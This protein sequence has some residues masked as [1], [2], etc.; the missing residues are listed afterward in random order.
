[1]LTMAQKIPKLDKIEVTVQPF[2]KYKRSQDL[3]ACFHA[4][5]AAI[6]GIADAI[7]VD[8]SPAH[9]VSLKFMPPVL[10]C[11]KDIFVVTI[12]EVE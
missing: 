12:T 4:A 2:L 9:V 7:L 11:P 8:D 1:M 5:K 10:S 6:D 3:G